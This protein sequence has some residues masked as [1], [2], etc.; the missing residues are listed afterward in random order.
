MKIINGIH[1]F[2][3]VFLSVFSSGCFTLDSAQIPFSG[4]KKHVYVSNYGW[5]LFGYVPL[6]CG[7]AA[8]ERLFPSVL[9]RDDVTLD[10]VQSRFV[11]VANDNGK[12]KIS[13]LAYTNTDSVLFE[14]PGLNIPIPLPYIFTYKEIQ[15]SGVME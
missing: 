2:L 13:E 6:L 9:F 10:K 1:I 7:N 15:L 11:K 5:Y 4:E 14:I 12:N 8:E 3:I